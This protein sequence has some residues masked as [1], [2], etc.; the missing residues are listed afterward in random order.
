MNSLHPNPRTQIV[1]TAVGLILASSL[2]LWGYESLSKITRV[3]NLSEAINRAK[4]CAKV[5]FE[6]KAE[7]PCLARPDGIV[8]LN[9]Q[10][11]YQWQVCFPFNDSFAS[12]YQVYSNGRV[13]RTHCDIDMFVAAQKFDSSNPDTYTNWP[14][15][16]KEKMKMVEEARKQGSKCTYY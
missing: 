2:A 15:P 14:T 4:L 5:N 8:N 16:I 3:H 12:C 7:V 13:Y 1:Y 6:S 11:L 10:T 9:G